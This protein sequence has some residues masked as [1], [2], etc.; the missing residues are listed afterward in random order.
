MT[1]NLAYVEEG[2]P[3]DD[4]ITSSHS[5]SDDYEQ[6]DM[7]I[8][9]TKPFAG[10]PKE[11][12]LKFSRQK[13][14]VYARNILTA[15]VFLSLILLLSL[16]IA[17]IAVS[18]PCQA[19]YQVSPVYEIC[20]KSYRDSDGD[21]VGDLKGIMEKMDYLSDTLGVKT[22]MVDDVIDP[23]NFRRV[24]PEVGTNQDAI[25]LVLLA[26]EKRMYVGFQLDPNYSHDT[27]EWFQKSL[28]VTM[29]GHEYYKD[30]YVWENTGSDTVP[31]NNWL[32]VSGTGSDSAWKYNPTRKEFYY[33][34][35]EDDKPDLNFR[36]E[37]LQREFKSILEFWLDEFNLDG[38]RFTS[39][40]Y[41]LE[42][43]HLR[44][45]QL[46]DEAMPP[47]YANMYPDFTRDLA[48]VHDV[49][50]EWRK[51]LDDFSTE[52]GVYRFMEVMTQPDYPDVGV[53]SRYYGNEYSKEADMPF[54][55]GLIELAGSI[56]WT[57]EN[58]A[59]KIYGWLESMPFE[60][61]W[62]NWRTGNSQSDRV[63]SRV[64]NDVMVSR[65]AA[66]TCLT[67]SGSCGIYYGDEIGMTS[68]VTG[69]E[70]PQ[71]TPMQWD[72]TQNA[73]FT[74]GEIPWMEVN[75]DY[76]TGT[77]VEDNVADKNSM[78]WLYKKLIQM[79]GNDVMLRGY[80][81]MIPT[82]GNNVLAYARELPGI[83]SI[84]VV[85][86]LSPGD[87][88]ILGDSLATSKLPG[89][90]TIRLVS[91]TPGE[92]QGERVPLATMTLKPKQAVVMEIEPDSLFTEDSSYNDKCFVSD[93]VRQNKI[94][95]LQ[96]A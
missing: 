3:R 93:P 33:H 82:S 73:G 37:N 60:E 57:S 19:N 51:V 91:D 27:H 22:L 79:N 61:N 87:D 76:L 31:P 11:V 6:S 86:N 39:V 62:P 40:Q 75:N 9:D 7:Q 36:S 72:T 95:I 89:D 17:F 65:I 10:M 83:N 42:S 70:N 46:I 41:L 1:E 85:I 67:L 43:E 77:N 44:D 30:F 63:T 55:Y 92:R 20:V 5:S 84:L 45:Q 96:K 53:T 8:D 52:P 94:G 58:L 35:Y 64:E 23:S 50:L 25:D 47:T 16:I 18:A 54:N 4:E 59:G 13:K 14:F 12:L 66:V 71:Q 68:G 69:V 88:V 48:Q 78:L 21:G 34:A 56:N 81:C 49:I 38:F 74:E 90:A 2:S 28:D 26:H 32:S 24:R 80:L 29:E 15:C